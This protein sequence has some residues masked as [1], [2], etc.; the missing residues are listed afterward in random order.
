[1]VVEYNGSSGIIP[2]GTSSAFGF[3]AFYDPQSTDGQT[4]ITATVF[5]FSGGEINLLNN[6]DSERLVYFE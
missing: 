6:T 5:P 4:T 1:M 3:Q 2:P